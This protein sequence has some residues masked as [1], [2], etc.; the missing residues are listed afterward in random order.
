MLYQPWSAPYPE[1]QVLQRMLQP[2]GPWQADRRTAATEVRHL[3]AHLGDDQ[4]AHVHSSSAGPS[5]LGSVAQLASSRKI[6]M[7]RQKEST[8]GN[9]GKEGESCAAFCCRCRDGGG[10]PPEANGTYPC[11][12]AGYSKLQSYQAVKVK[13]RGHIPPPAAAAAAPLRCEPTG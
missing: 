3:L 5:T 7:P 10:Q 12:L 2:A 4:L 9:G 8:E 13:G 6:N 1:L 11:C